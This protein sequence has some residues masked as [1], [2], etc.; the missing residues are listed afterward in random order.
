MSSGGVQGLI[1]VESSHESVGSC[2][3]WGGLGQGL[4]VMPP[5]TTMLEI[6]MEEE[7]D[8]L[9]QVSTLFLMIYKYC[10]IICYHVFIT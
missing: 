2:G 6:S 9:A 3:V 1:D 5:A 10:F 8:C 4:S 7:H